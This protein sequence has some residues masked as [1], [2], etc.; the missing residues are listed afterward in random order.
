MEE[1]M[2]NEFENEA[3]IDSRFVSIRD[4]YA[5]NNRMSLRYLLTQ[6][7]SLGIVAAKGSLDSIYEWGLQTYNDIMAGIDKAMQTEDIKGIVLVINSPGGVINGLFATA[8]YLLDAKAKKPILAVVESQACSAAYLLA[9]CCSKIVASPYSEIGCCGVQVEARDYS[10]YEK[11]VGILTKIFHSANAKKKNLSPFTPEGEA[12]LKK[13]LNDMESAYY[14]LIAE[15]RN[16]AKEDCIKDFGQGAVFMAEEAIEK[17]MI[18]A[19]A[20]M[21]DAVDEFEASLSEEDPEEL[22]VT[23]NLKDSSQTCAESEGENMPNQNANPSLDEVRAEAITQERAR[24]ASLNKMRTSAT[25]E[26]VEKAIKEGTSVADASQAIIDALVAQNREMAAELERIKPLAE[27][28][29]SQEV[30]GGI[31][32]QPE[33]TD[34]EKADALADAV[35][36]AVKEGK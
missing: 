20:S 21:D 23:V 14:D 7:G 24:V 11:K 15:G 22:S 17:G 5:L 3:L 26:I 27:Q 31:N 1:I 30:V 25:E 13:R 32:P 28:S 2:A 10:N 33:L 29:H 12:A 6:N 19:I 34:E 18:D 35:I 4:G 36:K 9:S 8:R 16:I